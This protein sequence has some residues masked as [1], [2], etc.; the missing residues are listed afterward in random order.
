MNFIFTSIKNIFLILVCFFYYPVKRRVFDAKN[1]KKIL[2]VQ[3]AK[4]GDMVCTTPVFRAVKEKYSNC[5]VFV[6]GNSINKE[7][8]VNNSDVDEYII[9]SGNFMTDLS[10]IKKENFDF[11]CITSPNFIN[12]VILCLSKIPLICVPFIENGWSPYETKSYKILRLLVKKV[13]HRMGY[14]APR[15]Y[16]K[17]LEPIGVYSDDTKKH[18]SFSEKAKLKIENLFKNENIKSEDFIVGISPSAGNKIKEW[19]ADRFAIVADYV[20]KKY[21][22]KIIVIG[23]KNDKK[24]VDEMINGVGTEMR[25]INTVGVF[26]IDELKALISRLNMFIS[27]DTGPIYIAEAFGVPTIDIVGPVD[28]KE[29]PPTGKFH[30]VVNIRNK[31]RPQLHVMNA[32]SYNYKEARRQIDVITPEM[33]IKEIENLYETIKN[34]GEKRH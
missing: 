25:L 12:L 34:N 7:L 26:N 5:K 1:I 6:G 9:L 16:L 13:S 33:V 21:G 3:T 23:T 28:E 15:E 19:P 30:K 2:I 27:V 11:A 29:Q 18:L 10:R 32:R 22:A 17:L 4:L 8:L 14:Y 24:E 31:E 20:Y